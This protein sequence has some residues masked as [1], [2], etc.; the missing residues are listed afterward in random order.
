MATIHGKLFSPRALEPV[1][2]LRVE[3]WSTDP[4]VERLLG[5]GVSDEDGTFTIELESRAEEVAFHVLR[6]DQ[7][8]L[9]T[10][11]KIQWSERVGEEP[12][13]LPLGDGALPGPNG[14][15]EESFNAS[16]LVTS[17]LGVAATG[18][19]VELWDRNVSGPTPLAAGTT[20][21][22]GRYSIDYDPAKLAGKARAD[23]EIRVLDPRRQGAELTRSAVTYQAAPR[24]VTDLV[25]EG[26]AVRR[27]PEY[28][29]LR[30]AL[31]PLLGDRSLAG[32][33][34]DGVTYLAESSGWD[35]RAVA[36]AVKSESLSAGTRIP[37]EHYYALLRAGAAG[38]GDQLHQ[39]P[40]DQVARALKIALERGVIA[41]SGSIGKT[42]EL[43]RAE[44]LRT[45]R[46]VRAPGAMSTLGE[47]LAPQLDDDAQE[48]FLEAYRSSADDPGSLWSRLADAG[49]D[50]KTV[51]RLRT[52]A[53]LGR[54]TLQN[55]PVVERLAREE[56]IAS[57]DDLAAGGFHDPKRWV[58][59]IG[60]R[61]PGGLTVE[62][63][64][65]ALAAQVNL[66]APTLV[67]AD[68]VRRDGLRL[69]GAGA[70]VADFL[71]GA[72]GSHTIGVEPVRTWDGF[73][74]LSA[75]A[76]NGAGLVERLYQMSPS[77]GSMVALANLGL[78]SAME[79]TSYPP[80]AFMD[81][82]GASFPSTY[83]A[84]SLHKKATDIHAT[85]LNLATMYLAA[86]A[87][88]NVY[89]LSGAIGRIAS[90]DGSD[91]VATATL[92]EL[93]KNMDY[94]SCEH[95]NSVF[96]PA[97]YLVELL[98]FLDLS[99]VPHTKD[100]PIDVLLGRRPDLQHILL[101]CENTNVALPYVDILNEV[102]EHYVVNGNLSGFRG[103]D[104]G[105]GSKTADLLADP[106]FVEDSA[107]D[108]TKDEVYPW[109]LP[110]D[111]PLAAMRLLLQ[112]FDTTL[113]DALELL[114]DP[115]DARRERLGLGDGEYRILT[116]S[117][118]HSLPEYFGE[119]AA[120]SIDDLNDAVA[121]AK[122]F[123]RRVDISYQDLAAILKTRFVNPAIAIVP[124]LQLL[125][126]PIARIQDW[127]DGTLTDAELEALF[128][129]GL[130][131]EP[132][133][134][135]PL[136]WL[137]AQGDDIMGL[138]TLTDVGAEP[139]E[140]DFAQVELRFALPKPA[141]NRLT[142]IAYLRLGRFIRL[143]RKLAWSIEL[144]D[145]LVTTFLATPAAD[146]TPANIDAAF[147]SLLNRIAN[148]LRLLDT[149]EVS[150]KKVAD[151]LALWDATLTEDVRLDRLAGMLRIGTVDLRHLAEI[152]GIDP[153]AD[154]MESDVPSML[155]FVL[156]WRAVK[157][158]PL[159]VADL[160]YLLRHQDVTGKL[161]PSGDEQLRDV[162]AL[163]D[164]LSAVENDV[165]L[166]VA[167]PDLNGAKAK[168]ALVYDA[169]VVDR[170]FAFV[171]HTSTYAAPFASAEETLPADLAETSPELDF[172]PFA[173]RLT[174]TGIM[175]AATQAS[176]EAAADALDLGDVTEITT[177]IELDAFV[178]AFKVAVQTL[179]D[180]GEAGVASFA[181][182]YP[183]LAAIVT[184]V[185]ALPEPAAKARSILEAILPELRATLKA[186][187]LRTVLAGITK[188]DSPVI[189]AIIGG[190]GVLQAESDTTAGVLADFL[191][192]EEAVELTADDTY[193]LL[194]DPV[195]AGDYIL[196]VG[197]PQN[198]SVRL[199]LDGDEVMP[200]T[201][202][203]ADGEVATSLPIALTTGA[204]HR[205]ELTIASL[206]AGASAALR[207]RTRA[208]AKSDVPAAR[209]YSLAAAD[210]ARSS[211][212]R[213]RKA[214]LL[215]RSLDLTAGELHHFAAVE[216]AT[217]GFLDALDTD[218]SIVEPALHAQWARIE[219]LLWFAQLKADHEP[220]PDT[221]LRLFGQPDGTTPQG[222]LLIA[223]IME[224]DEPSLAAILAHKG[225]ALADLAGLDELRAVAR[226]MELVIATQRP[227][228][229]LIDWAVPNPDATLLR[230]AKAALRER[231]TE[232]AWRES[233]QS[234]N[235]PLRSQRR[236]ALVAYILFHDPPG[237]D[238]TTPDRLYEHFLLDVQMDP[239]MQTSRIRLALS[240][241]QMFVNR[242]LM[243]LE[244]NVSPASIRADHWRW[245]QRY[246]V[247]EA[248]RRVFVHPENWLEP[249]LRDGKSSFFLELESEL[250]K[251]DITD[252]L[253]EEAYLSYLKKLDDVARLELVAAYLHQ[254]Q[255]SNPDDDVLHV[256]GRTNGK[257]RQ[258]WYRRFEYG[259]WTPW[260]KVPLNIEGD[261]LVPIVWKSQLFV[262]WVTELVKAD[263]GD[264]TKSPETMG[265]EGW[266]G[267]A[268][269]TAELTLSWGEL[270]R[271]RWTSPK[272]SEMNE[273][274]TITGLD[275]FRPGRLVL[276]AHTERPSASVS[277]RL[278][279][280][281]LYLGTG[282][283][284]YK[285]TFTSKH[286][287]P[288]VEQP[289]VWWQF[290]DDP[291]QF[292][293]DLLVDG[294]TDYDYDSN[295]LRLFDRT[296]EV[297]VEQPGDGSRKQELVL[298]KSG[299]LLEGFRVR[300]ILAPVENQWEAPFIYS[301]EHSVFIVQGDELVWDKGWFDH[302]Y[303]P[304]PIAQTEI[305]DIPQLYEEPVILDKGD[306]VIHPWVE[307]VDPNY[308]TIIKD[309][310]AFDFEGTMFNATGRVEVRAGLAGGH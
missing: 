275:A 119:P 39:A 300:P 112:A 42:V 283:T 193:E 3:A 98:E 188:A 273:P 7:L 129:A 158:S 154:D 256:F 26:A 41:D 140:C 161:T 237:P 297:K 53:A 117:G 163:R 204:L 200:T 77:N 137:T 30:L 91:V 285:V 289:D 269:T 261:L 239:C 72:H 136:A 186:Q 206:P 226:A 124:T 56:R 101:S 302:F 65:A 60:D 123:C 61:V 168:V 14:A 138:I 274:L 268:L 125:H 241:V 52:T 205:L 106:Q 69:D 202:V 13:L 149:L 310:T 252:E 207:W 51:A 21:E 248:N 266:G 212:L 220:D 33:D 164:A 304:G 257:T 217:K 281:V 127:F 298:T 167:N 255:P 247:W 222:G 271:G 82:F 122:T 55:A 120:A 242:C 265:G 11:G 228:S 218:G 162:K 83:E 279:L 19:R 293:Y 182:D 203:G 15:G 224:W 114:G 93:F 309:N 150:K 184:A 113:A 308:T 181:E 187:A 115:A 70:E 128:P 18:L 4:R 95:C 59:V 104:M 264:R 25:V 296:F 244:K 108:Q 71:T 178:A 118:F 180:A 215:Q 20:D 305:K 262:F 234:V 74:Q 258:Y 121:I 46:D 284:A 2:K 291:M 147:A 76:Q 87:N 12:V 306:P 165:G 278:V 66:S 130:D 107:Y 110:F 151:W 68:L 24:A 287:P 156:S 294:Q 40:D 213:V 233:M 126:T 146:L 111:M 290:V 49:F 198:T 29:R 48:R 23:L 280:T 44:A 62:S 102:L 301:D 229:D 179:R 246:R 43:H 67:A 292:N 99:A 57:L 166:A 254:R 135:D 6:G 38:S 173:K 214:A 81:K 177:Q 307:V 185:E 295:S 141:D 10:T 32:V 267:N 235:D 208:I 34:A 143:W 225:L 170:L 263:S 17:E 103:H 73:D 5:E 260:E 282:R 303:D 176:L 175:S 288:L 238:I 27:M 31:E 28:E 132:F 286:A 153:L 223:N 299:N 145:E 142:E 174:F 219:R 276:S 88:P 116:D 86:R 199:E 216:T 259:Y 63:Y 54:L 210:V 97:A 92:E 80:D 192:L 9:D 232:A 249:E 172:D 90:A 75:E 251:S 89:V 189:D 78:G 144:T 159:K 191:A 183:E 94:C 47:M 105:S 160:D 134:G 36:M 45:L 230:D 22:G 35:A 221:F 109:S 272:S 171:T 194:L 195:A 169:A 197:A 209:L 157:A 139:V 79:V 211:L 58:E 50:E 84:R 100:N 8:V 253:A 227:A 1:G 37:A 131:K 85:T 155:R 240:T 245:M 270:Y 152:G 250:L 148:F 196:Y 96:S 277:E 243:N 133:G 236:D 231:M 64:A 201:A 190:P 16:G